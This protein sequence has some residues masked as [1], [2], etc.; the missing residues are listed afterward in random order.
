VDAISSATNLHTLRLH[1]QW[2]P[3]ELPQQHRHS[4]L[5]SDEIRLLNGN[6][7]AFDR[8]LTPSPELTESDS[9]L[10]SDYVSDN[11]G[12]G[13]GSAHDASLNG[14]PRAAVSRLMAAY[15]FNTNF[16]SNQSGSSEMNA[17]R[18]NLWHRN[19]NEN[20]TAS[21]NG[22]NGN[23]NIMDASGG[24][25]GVG[26]N[27][28]TDQQQYHRAFKLEHARAVMD[29]EGSKLRVMVIEGVV[30]TGRWIWDNENAE[31]KFEVE[32]AGEEE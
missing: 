9:D 29:R 28:G 19:G 7:W 31:A 30:Y 27:G 23:K 24:G 22:R 16:N 20:G 17:R 1:V 25:G 11:D 21:W 5:P 18:D 14:P 12:V 26:G 6:P 8:A 3:P 13:G 4:W 2:I 10:D 15:G 32:C